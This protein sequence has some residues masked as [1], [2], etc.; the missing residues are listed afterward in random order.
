MASGGGFGALDCMIKTI[1]NNASLLRRKNMFE[2]MKE[3]GNFKRKDAYTYNVAT[4]A[5][6]AGIKLRVKQD[7]KR[8]RLKL[9]IYTVLIS[10]VICYLSFLLFSANLNS[11]NPGISFEYQKSITEPLGEELVVRIQYYNEKYKAITET[12]YYGKRH[13]TITSWYPTGELFRNAEYF[14][15]ALKNEVFY[16]PSGNEITDFKERFTGDISEVSLID[17]VSKKFN[18]L[19]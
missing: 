1:R 6:I 5:E 18:E 13:G 3:S 16:Y 19:Y 4:P 8:R 11:I 12:L 7:Q 15:G 17:K 14:N 9:V 10:G 2:V